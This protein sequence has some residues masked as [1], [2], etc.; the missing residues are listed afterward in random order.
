MALDL[1]VKLNNNVV[2][3]YRSTIRVF[4]AF[5]ILTWDFDLVDKSSIDSNG[6][7]TSISNYAQSGYEIRISTYDIGIGTGDFVGTY[8]QTGLVSSQEAFWK[9]FGTSIERGVI[10]YGQISAVD[11]INRRSEWYTFSFLYNSL[12]YVEDVEITP[13][14]PLATDNLQLS[15][16]FYDNDGD[17]ESGTVIRWFKNGVYQRQFDNALII[18]SSFL[19]VNDIWNVDIYPFDNYE[20]GSRVTSDQTKISFNFVEVSDL[21]VFPNNP[22]PNDFLKANYIVS[23]NLEKNNV[24]IR[25]YVNN[26][27]LQEL[28]DQQYVR[29]LLQEGDE[30]RFE[31]KHMD[32][33]SYISS[34]VS[35]IVSA[36][37]VVTNITVDGKINALDV[38][39]ITPY[40]RWE[41][42]VPEG[43]QV[44][45]VS[46]KIGTFAEADNIYSSVLYGNPSSFSIPINILE[47]GRDYYISIAESDTLTFNKYSFSHFRVS[48]SRW[49]KSVS[50][51]VG[52]TIDTLFVVKTTGDTNE[53]Q[54]MRIN[55]G[56]RFAEIRIYN[57]KIQL[58]SGSQIEYDVST[59]TTTI[60]TVIGKNDDILIYV[61]KNLV[62]DGTGLFTV[63]S[64][65]KQLEIGAYSD[66]STLTVNYKYLFYTVSGYF[67][68]LVSDE[69]ANLQ[70]HTYL[71]FRDNEIIS[72]QGY[73]DG[74][75][76]FG[77]NPYNQNDNS[78]IY[79]LKAGDLQQSVSVPRT[80][81][82]INSIDKSPDGKLTVCAHAKGTTIITGYFINPFNQELIF[83]DENNVVDET[84]PT[85]NGWEIVKNID[86]EAVYFDS[87]GL[88]I[89]TID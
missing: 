36:D 78:S 45:Y 26:Q 65:E 63:P 58:I 77:L 62:I 64:S 33:S 57:N 15:Y 53:Y 88:N 28:N 43:K 30:V 71:E 56:N 89:N 80:F 18:D 68:P 3:S 19:Q 16:N 41:D 47:K 20:Y 34:F 85:D 9:Y 2:S 22:N 23:N 42:F 10:Y 70:F 17:V 76:I 54:V 6:V 61:N 38:S 5:P 11:E 87:D 50:N 39:T 84:F 24:S 14:V 86:Y 29:P 13:L 31:I 46:I 55:D 79:A 67:V 74:K 72:L 1:S 82:P 51:S 83:V 27:I 32:S 52:W 73:T 69:Y 81:A 59:T 35:T 75:Y 37:F 44:N 49:E 12:P 25:W 7:S 60:L 66:E 8:A 48:G 40:I 4:D 21:K